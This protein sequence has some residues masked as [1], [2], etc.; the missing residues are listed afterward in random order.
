MKEVDYHACNTADEAGDLIG[1]NDENR[2][3][4]KKSQNY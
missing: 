4:N 3:Y 2:G 1:P